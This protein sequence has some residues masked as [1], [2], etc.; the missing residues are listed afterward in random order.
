MEELSYLSHLLGDL[1]RKPRRRRDRRASTGLQLCSPEDPLELGAPQERAAVAAGT[2]LLLLLEER[3]GT[4]FQRGEL[5]SLAQRSMNSLQ[6]PDKAAIT[7]EVTRVLDWLANGL[8]ERQEGVDPRSWGDVHYDPAPYVPVLRGAVADTVDV[9][10]EYFSHNRG[11]WSRRRVT[12]LRLEAR[13]TLVAHCHLR[14]KE[15][16]F[17]LSRIRSLVLLNG[18]PQPGAAAAEIEVAT[19]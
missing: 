9:E 4:S 18:A 3:G 12:P 15:R 13:G 7:D 6:G 19:Q 14:G 2:L 8:T 1:F 5:I 11:Q 16:R 10:I 17:R